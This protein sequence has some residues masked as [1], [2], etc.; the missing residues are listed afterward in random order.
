MT[1]NYK[2]GSTKTQMLQTM[3]RITLEG[4]LIHLDLDDENPLSPL[5]RVNHFFR[6]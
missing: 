4:W 5:S 6:S 2:E 1:L 3:E